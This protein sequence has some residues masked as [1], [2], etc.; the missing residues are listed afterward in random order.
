MLLRRYEGV[1]L[2]RSEERQPLAMLNQLPPPEGAMFAMRYLQ[3]YTSAQLGEIFHLPPGT[4][5]YKLSQA[6]KRLR[7]MLGE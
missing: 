1:P 2:L 7:E 3:G 4:V 6:R 5:R